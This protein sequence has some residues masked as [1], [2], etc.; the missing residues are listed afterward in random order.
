MHRYSIKS[1]LVIAIIY[2][3]T[4]VLCAILTALTI[5][6]PCG[7]LLRAKPSILIGL[8]LMLILGFPLSVFLVESEFNILSVIDIT[9]QCIAVFFSV[10]YFVHFGSRLAQREDKTLP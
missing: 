3:T 2:I 7:Y 6:L 5:A 1:I 9:S 8:L 10:Y 4:D